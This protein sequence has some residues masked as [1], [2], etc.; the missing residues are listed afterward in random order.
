MWR[1]NRR[2][3]IVFVACFC[4][5]LSFAELATR[6]WESGAA[7]G[8]EATYSRKL[9]QIRG[10]QFDLLLLGDSTAHQGLVPERLTDGS[11][12]NAAL[13]SGSGIVA[14]RLAQSVAAAPKQLI[15]AGILPE[16]ADT[17]EPQRHERALM[18]LSERARWSPGTADLVLSGLSHFYLRRNQVRAA[19]L[20]VTQ[21]SRTR[22][23]VASNGESPL[24]WLP[25]PSHELAPTERDALARD[26][27]DLWF[28]T[29][30]TGEVRLAALRATLRVWPGS[31][32]RILLLMPM[33]SS[34]RKR[35]AMRPEAPQL[36]ARWQTLA[37]TTQSTLLDCMSA[38][39]DARFHD[40]DHLDA[41]GARAFSDELGVWLRDH[42]QYPAGCTQAR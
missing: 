17:W 40:D 3:L 35:L 18:T 10:Q 4:S 28:R 41:E 7:V 25:Q 8:E 31:T 29:P 32:E 37:A 30:S 34:I 5:V 20:A 33:S 21:R 11:V 9:S 24:G 14:E 13:Q 39:P 38:M 26:K 16:V 6:F 15:Y 23:R 19:L 1:T 2:S 36:H 12:F 42:Q 27:M 22:P